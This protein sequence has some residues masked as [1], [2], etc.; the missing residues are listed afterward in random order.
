MIFNKLF[1]GLVVLSL[2]VTSVASCN[3]HKGD[4][5]PT[6]Q[7]SEYKPGE[8]FFIYA[9]ATWLESLKNSNP[10]QSY[11]YFHNLNEA[12]NARLQV[13]KD[14][15]SE[16]KML[17][18]GAA[19]WK[20]NLDAS[21][22]LIED[23]VLNMLDD[24]N[25]KEDLYVFFGKAIRLGAPLA[26]TLHTAICREDNTFGYYI[27]PPTSDM[28]SAAATNHHEPTKRLNRYNQST[29]SG[30]T[31]IDYILEGVGLDPK[32]YLYDEVSEALAENL[33]AMDETALKKSIATAIL[34]ELIGFCS[35]EDAQG[36][37]HG[38]ANTVAEYIDVFVEKD[39]GYF[40]SYHYSHKYPTDNSEAAF[41][42][43]GNDL[44]ASFRKRLENN[45]WL[46]PSTQQAAIEKLDYMGKIYGTPKKWIVTDMPQLKGEMLVSDV[47]EI[48]KCRYDVIK[49]LLGKSIKEYSPIHYMFYSPFESH[50]TYTSNAF[51]DPTQ[52]LFY[53]LP[54]FMLE[55]AYTTDMD[56]CKFYAY[57][58]FIIGHEI[59]HGFDQ[60]GAPYDKNGEQKNWWAE[61]DAAKFAELNALRVENIS[62]YEIVP[63]MQADGEMTVLE[64]VAD[65]GGFNIAYDLWVNKL[66]ERGVEGDE[67]NEMK[68]Q[69]FLNY[70][71]LFSEK[72]PVAEMVNRAQSDIHSAGHIRVNSVVQHIDDWYELFDI[73]ESDPLYLAP[74]KRL[75]IW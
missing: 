15:M 38:Q 18:Q 19:K 42:T 68:K 57:W 54:P 60:L 50:Y 8:D 23:I 61:G 11:G 69:F 25:T 75:T 1:K 35:D 40:T 74:E 41:A 52:N 34:T 31:T 4:N 65:L 71:A 64:D 2:L 27:V 49:S 26:G 17:K 47:L 53:V 56:E 66:K 48:K 36:I 51:Y 12:N 16:Y 5:T 10:Q 21:N 33:E 55:P 39:L 9:N 72:M 30:K 6:K 7:P 28:E 44:I 37:S 3:K 63:G 62:S 32:Y 46:S 14:N 29:R 73:D 59:T 58:G 43:L 45:Q 67:L 70:A 13:V 24:V 22:Q 20:A